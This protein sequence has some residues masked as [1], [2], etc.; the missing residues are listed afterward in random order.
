MTTNAFKPPPQAAGGK[1]C[2]RPGL[3]G[4]FGV[5]RVGAELGRS[6]VGRSEDGRPTDRAFGPALTGTNC[7]TLGAAQLWS[8]PQVRKRNLFSFFDNIQLH[9]R[10][11]LLASPDWD[12][13]IGLVFRRVLLRLL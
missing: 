11:L 4:G 8:G 3:F 5:D 12:S 1:F 10:S 13:Q 9:H 6:S 7:E 2:L